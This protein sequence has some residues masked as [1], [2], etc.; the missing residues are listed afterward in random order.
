MPIATRAQMKL[1]TN[2]A[3]AWPGKLEQKIQDLGPETVLGFIAEPVVGATA[4]V[5][6]PVPG[7]FQKIRAVC[8][9]YGILLIFDEVMCGMGRT[10]S[11]FACDQEQV[12][13]DILLAAKGLGAGYQP[14]GAMLVADFI[15][16]AIV[17]GSGFFQHGHTYMAHPTACAAALA[18]QQE[19]E[20]NDLLENVRR[21]GP[22]LELALQDRF[23]NHPYIGDIR[24]RGLFWGLEFVADRQSKEPLPAA[25]ALHSKI[26][27][28][29][30]EQGLICYP[31]GG[32]IDG[33]RG[34]HV[35]LAPPFIIDD[36]HVEEITG[37]LGLAIEGAFSDINM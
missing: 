29:A 18:V 22:K 13:P 10:G 30:M 37:K 1:M 8:D 24:G 23:G 26:K 31:G 7:Y 32:T 14:V 34:N 33:Q 12:V 5:L 27:S 3:H 36:N 17:E 19:I 21:M 35:L 6:P 28:R 25:L 9:K 16:R 11:L 2:M 4:G 15:Y 20:D